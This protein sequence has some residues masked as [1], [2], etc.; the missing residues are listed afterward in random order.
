[1]SERQDV[2]TPPRPNPLLFLFAACF[3]GGMFLN[4]FRG[5]SDYLSIFLGTSALVLLGVDV[6]KLTGR[7]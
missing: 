5:G 6:G 4:M 3:L 7:K 1:V 2:T